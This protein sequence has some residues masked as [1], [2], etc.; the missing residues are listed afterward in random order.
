MRTNVL[1]LQ[2]ILELYKN[3]TSVRRKEKKKKDSN[4]LK[5]SEERERRA[6]F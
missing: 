4:I 6:V 3:N 5:G 2:I 1:Y